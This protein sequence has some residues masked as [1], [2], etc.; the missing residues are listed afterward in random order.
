ME[1]IIFADD[2]LVSGL[3]FLPVPCKWVFQ[4]GI[5][6]RSTIRKQLH[7]MDSE[8]TDSLP[9]IKCVAQKL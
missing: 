9:E 7:L 3:K 8:Y 6:M 4:R 1:K 5:M 2:V